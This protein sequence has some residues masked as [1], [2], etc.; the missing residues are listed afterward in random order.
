MRRIAYV[1]AVPFALGLLG[2][3]SAP[4]QADAIVG[5]WSGSGTVRHDGGTD[6]VR[7]RVSYNKGT[8]RTYEVYANCAH[9]NGTFKQSGRVVDRGG[10][11]YTGRVYSDQYQVTGSVTVSVRGNS[12]S[13][14]VNSP[15]GSAK[16]TLRRQ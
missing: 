10:N 15:R 11:R 12:Q 4:A 5:N 2:T 8:G 14:S 16:L 1:L 9:P 13:I 7:C 6:A 3:P